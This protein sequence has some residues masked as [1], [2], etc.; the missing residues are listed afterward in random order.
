MYIYIGRGA[1]LARKLDLLELW[2]CQVSFKIERKGNGVK[3]IFKQMKKWLA[4]ELK[5]DVEKKGH[6]KI[7]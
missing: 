4:T 3:N 5:M 2:F 7:H 1:E 6:L